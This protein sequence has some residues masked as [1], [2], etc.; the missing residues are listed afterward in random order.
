MG[1]Q[2]HFVLPFNASTFTGE[3]NGFKEYRLNA[4]E[5]RRSSMNM[6]ST[7]PG[8]YSQGH[9]DSVVRVHATRSAEADASFLLPHLRKNMDILDCGC[10]P[11]SI[12]CDFASIVSDGSVAGIDMSPEVLQQ[13]RTVARSRGLHNV[14]FNTADISTG[15][16]FPDD[17]FDVV[18]CHQFLLHIPQPVQAV[19]EMRRVCKTGGLVACREGDL[20][21]CFFYPEISGVQNFMAALVA[22]VSKYGG[23]SKAGRQL[24]VWAQEAGFEPDNI[25]VSF[26]VNG[27]ATQ[28][29]RDLLAGGFIDRLANSQTRENFL[30]AGNS[31]KDLDDMRRDL[32][33]WRVDP[34]GW[35]FTPQGEILCTK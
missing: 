29:R 2:R 27:Y 15:L 13:A 3:S 31:E 9:S 16:P 32:D 14:T 5:A 25:T 4:Y 20:D 24:H 23:S 10:G 33:S 18:Y 28:E 6:A 8:T 11:G 26:G 12:T 34:N 22:D 30:E 17:T 35:Q 19:R 1:L 7:D 21:E